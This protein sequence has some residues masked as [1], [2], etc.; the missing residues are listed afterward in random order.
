MNHEEGQRLGDP[1]EFAL[2]ED[3]G[4][5]VREHEPGHPHEGRDRDEGFTPMPPERRE[6]LLERVLGLTTADG[7]TGQQEPAVTGGTAGTTEPT[8]GSVSTD[9]PAAND[10]G[11]RS[12]WLGYLSASAA[13]AAALV[14]IVPS[15]RPDP[16]PT[17]ASPALS[18]PPAARP[19]F[20]SVRLDGGG[21]LPAHQGKAPAS[22]ARAVCLGQPLQLTLAA[23]K[24]HRIDPTVPLELVLEATP[25]RGS[26]HRLTFEVGRDERFAWAD[27]G[28]ALVYEGP[29]ERLAPLAPGPWTLQLSAGA[30]G[31]CGRRDD[32]SGCTTLPVQV[33]EVVASSAC[34]A[35]P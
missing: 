13:V 10:G 24:G 31:T 1:G 25:P 14:V 21:S 18:A 11:R 16:T 3:L 2:L 23:A 26:A 33:I 27:E 29:L 30:P 6:A 34:H 9:E 17:L 20:G 4:R 28:R 8:A 15:V 12:R 7:R 19:A 32:R 35:R 5:W 22:D